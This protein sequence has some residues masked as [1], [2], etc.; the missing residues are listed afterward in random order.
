MLVVACR[1]QQEAL[2]QLDAQRSKWVLTL[3][4]PA[5][6]EERV[7]VPNCMVR[8]GPTAAAAAPGCPVLRVYS[9]DTSTCLPADH[10]IVQ[11]VSNHH[12]EAW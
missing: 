7:M 6:M 12:L 5:G 3:L 4:E 1:R 11:A 8:S 10:A 9:N 2:P